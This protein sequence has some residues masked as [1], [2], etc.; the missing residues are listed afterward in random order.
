MKKT[1]SLVFILSSIWMGM[2]Q[3]PTPATE[4][5][6]DF[7]LNAVMAVM[8]NAEDLEDLEKKINDSENQVNNLD[9]N[10]DE[11]I[12]VV[13]IVEYDEGNTG[14]LV[15]RAVLG[16]SEFQDIATIEI[17]KHGEDDISLQVIGDPELYGEDYILEPAPEDSGNTGGGD[18]FFEPSESLKTLGMAVFVS[19]HRW[20]PIRPLFRVG[21][22]AFVSSVVWRPYPA[23]F[24]VRRPILR[25]TWRSR[26]R[27]YNRNRYRSSRNRYSR[28]ASRMYSNKRKKSNTAMKNAGPKPTANPNSNKTSANQAQKSTQTSAKSTNVSSMST[29]QSSEKSSTQQKKQGASTNTKATTRTG[30]QQKSRNNSPPVRKKN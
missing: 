12:D 3:E 7:D 25:S 21:R 15:L 6:E 9:L 8:E 10:K 27:R 23:W 14:L 18:S 30:S 5:A 29:T 17:E 4:A 28:N 13:K 11:E 19:V 16:E 26:T 2:S 20:R 22:V 24:V 1:T